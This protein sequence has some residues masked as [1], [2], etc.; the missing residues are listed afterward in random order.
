MHATPAQ[1]KRAKEALAEAECYIRNFVCHLRDDGIL[2]HYPE[3][4]AWA[5]EAKPLVER[6]R[7]A[8]IKLA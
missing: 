1:T 8:R 6:L 4:A 5:D 7:K 3:A 2:D